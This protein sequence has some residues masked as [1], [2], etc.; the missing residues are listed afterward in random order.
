M[1]L[2]EKMLQAKPSDS[3]TKGLTGSEIKSSKELA[4]IS[5]QIELKRKQMGMN[6][7]EFAHFMNVSQGMI[8]KWESGEYNFSILTLNTI[9]EKLGLQFNPVLHDPYTETTDHYGRIRTSD[10]KCGYRSD[11]SWSTIKSTIIRTDRFEGIA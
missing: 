3:L 7:T 10:F 9:C 6:Q 11:H 2:K 5:A 8:S 1:S 4:L